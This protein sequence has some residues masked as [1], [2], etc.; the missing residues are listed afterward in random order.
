MHD[1]AQEIPGKPQDVGPGGML[2]AGL[3][4][5]DTEWPIDVRPGPFPEEDPR[6]D[7]TNEELAS[8]PKASW[9]A[10]I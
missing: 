3:S 4:L 2:L 6:S 1:R 7:H 10:V 9:F 8:G 5:Q